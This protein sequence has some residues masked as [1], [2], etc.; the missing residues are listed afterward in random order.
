MSAI[1]STASW[2]DLMESCLS[3][4]ECTLDLFEGLK[5]LENGIYH[6]EERNRLRLSSECQIPTP[7][8]EA[9]KNNNVISIGV[10]ESI[11]RVSFAIGDK[12]YLWNYIS[13]KRWNSITNIGSQITCVGVIK[14]KSEI[15]V[16]EIEYVLIIA[17]KTDIIL[18]ALEFAN[19]QIDNDMKGHETKFKISINETETV[20]KIIGNNNGRIFIGFENGNVSEFKYWNENSWFGTTN[21]SKC[22]LISLT[23]PLSSSLSSSLSTLSYK[24]LDYVGHKLLPTNLLKSSYRHKPICDLIINENI[25]N[26]KWLF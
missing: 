2:G 23:S 17:T 18:T 1:I 15:F 25:N 11:N 9:F 8:I 21:I 16:K 5:T 12:L 10:F 20:K 6:N 24:M 22:E 13:E 7:I 14:A 19:D 26:D 4:D 3:H